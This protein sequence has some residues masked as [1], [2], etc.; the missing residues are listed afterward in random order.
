MAMIAA[1]AGKDRWHG[2]ER[3]AL[4]KKKEERDRSRADTDSGQRRV[5]KPSLLNFWFQRPPNQSAAR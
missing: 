2:G 5:I 4:L 1:P 3:A